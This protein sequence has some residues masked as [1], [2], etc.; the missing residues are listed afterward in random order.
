MLSRLGFDEKWV[1]LIYGCLSTVQYNIVSSGY[2]LGPIVPSRGLRQGDPISPYLFLICAEGF[3]TLIRRY[4]ERKWIHGCRVANGA[5]LV[6]H[7]LFADDSFLYCKATNEEVSYIINLLE[8]FAKALGQ[9]VNFAKS[10]V[11]YSS[12]TTSTMT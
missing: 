7:I 6:S 4:E 1:R 5:P 2:T 9:W 3:S 11:F 8:S 10:T 12:S